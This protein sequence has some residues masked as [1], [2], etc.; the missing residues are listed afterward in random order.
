M[1]GSGESGV[2]PLRDDTY[3]PRLTVLALDAYHGGSHR[4]FIDG[5]RRHTRHRVELLDLPGRHWKWRMRHA[6]WTMAGRAAALDG[7]FDAVL[8]TDMLDLAAWRGLAPATLARVPAVIYFHESQ[9]VY[10]DPRRGERDEHFLFTNLLSAAAAEQVWW[11]SG[12][13]RDA[14]LHAAGDL[15]GRVPDHPPVDALERVRAR[16]RVMYPGW[17]FGPAAARLPVRRSGPPH[18]LWAARWESDKDP[19]CFLAAL[20]RLIAAGIDFRV[21]LLGQRGGTQPPAFAAA[22]ARLG[23]RV[24]HWG[25]LDSREA[26]QAALAAAD[27]IVSTA[28]HEFFGIA[29]VEAV[30]AGCFP[31]VPRRQAYPEVLAGFA[32]PGL[33]DGTHAGDADDLAARLAELCRRTTAGTLWQGDPERGRAAVAAYAWPV[34]AAAMDAAL[35]QLVGA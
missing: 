18:L 33:D 28:L 20:D 12:F 34:R 9:I 13:H 5:W 24:A 25:W 10:P 16:S 32:R 23:D 26:Y 3:P 4:E 8:A 21:S 35:D 27:I 17:E 22:R 30:A 1:A 11:N 2:S 29:V 14:F 15:L 31:L 7:P 19:D 6:A